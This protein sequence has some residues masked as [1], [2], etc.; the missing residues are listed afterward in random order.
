[1]LSFQKASFGCVLFAS[2]ILDHPWVKNLDQ[3]STA[4]LPGSVRDG[5]SSMSGKRKFRVAAYAAVCM[6]RQMR[7]LH[8]TMSVFSG[9]K[10]LSQQE[11]TRLHQEFSKVCVPCL[12]S[13]PPETWRSTRTNVWKSAVLFFFCVP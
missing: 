10:K 1:M 3:D 7:K 13:A 4:P 8:N 6:A 5:I 11:L 2:Q 9:K 12:G